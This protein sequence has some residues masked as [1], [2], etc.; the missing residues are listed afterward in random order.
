MFGRHSQGGSGKLSPDQVAR[1][2]PPGHPAHGSLLYQ[3]LMTR[4]PRQGRP[5]A[6]NLPRLR[7]KAAA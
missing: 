2:W 6:P 3:W 5:W 4:E 1:R 7:D